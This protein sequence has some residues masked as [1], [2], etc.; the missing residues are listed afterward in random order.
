MGLGM[1]VERGLGTVMGFMELGYQQG[2]WQCSIVS[3]SDPIFVFLI[4]PWPWVYAQVPWDGGA[5][6]PPHDDREQGARAT[7]SFP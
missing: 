3:Q 6:Y 5:S 2:E 1:Q 7:P 4:P